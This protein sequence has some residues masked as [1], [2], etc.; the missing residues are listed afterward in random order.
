MRLYL[1]LIY[2]ICFICTSHAIKPYKN[3]QMCSAAIFQQNHL[4]VAHKYL[5]TTV[6]NLKNTL[7][8]L[9]NMHTRITNNA[10]IEDFAIVQCIASN[11]FDQKNYLNTA[12]SCVRT[13]SECINNQIYMYNLILHQNNMQNIIYITEQINILFTNIRNAFR[14]YY[15][16]FSNIVN[17]LTHIEN[18]FSTRLTRMEHIITQIEEKFTSY[19]VKNF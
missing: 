18:V 10:T 4:A 12:L 2:M 19:N 16:F 8:N 5:Q 1:F 13:H 11:I 3:L 9:Y 6:N 15:K 7:I 17:D 14:Y